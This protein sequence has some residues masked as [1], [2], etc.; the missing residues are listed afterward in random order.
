MFGIGI[1][2]V[3]H[4][5]FLGGAVCLLGGF[6]GASFAEVLDRGFDVSICFQ[7]RLLTLHHARVGAVTELLHLGCTNRHEN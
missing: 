6:D 1:D 2:V 7:E 3:N 5:P 4:D